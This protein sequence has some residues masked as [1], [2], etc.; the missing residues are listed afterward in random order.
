MF[1]KEVADKSLQVLMTKI[2]EDYLFFYL[3][4][5]CGENQGY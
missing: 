4:I 3:E 5:R 2:M 1:Q